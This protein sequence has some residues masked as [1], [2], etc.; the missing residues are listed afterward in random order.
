VLWSPTKDNGDKERVRDASDIVRIV[1][2]SVALRPKG[3]EYSGLCPF[4]DDHRP[5]MNVIPSKQIFHCFVCGASGDVFTFVQKFH[6]MD[7][8]EALEYLAERAGIALT[9]FRAAEGGS[10]TPVGPNRRSLLE[11]NSE[12]CRF[13]RG[14]LAHAEHGKPGREV[15]ERRRISPEMVE[16][17]QIGLAPDRW[18]GLLLWARQRKL[19]E[20]SLLAAG[21]A[22]RRESGDGA[23]D[24]LRHRLIFPIHN[25]AGQVIAFGGRK[26]RDEDEP[27]YLNS[28]E[29]PLFN[30]S[31]TL[32]ALHLATS[33][34]QAERTAIICEGYTDVIA[35]HQ[36]GFTNAVATLGTALTR[37]HA[38]ELRL[39]CDKVVLLFD[40]D[41][42][43][44]RAAD[45]AVPI[46]FAEQIDVAIAT[47]AAHT[48][49]KDP[50]E[51]LKR[52]GGPDVFRNALASAQD[53]IEYRLAR[54]RARLAGAGLSALEKGIVQE[55]SDF[56]AM[57]LATAAPQR[58]ELIER[59]LAEIS[60]LRESTIRAITPV[61][62]SAPARIEPA[63][64]NS[65]DAPDHSAEL[66]RLNTGMLT[67]SEHLLGC[68]LCDG[69]LW[70]TLPEHDR[71]LVAPEAYSSPLVARVATL[72][73]SLG[74][75]EQ[76]P[77]LSTLLQATEDSFIQSAAVCLMSRIAAETDRDDARLAQ[78]W[79]ACLGRAR[80]D[81]AHIKLASSTDDASDPAAKLAQ[82]REIKLN[83]GADRRVMPRPRG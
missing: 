55:I 8:R 24:A 43:G 18:D 38:R 30:K 28:P 52:E 60:G 53:L 51:L 4:H 75:D 1:G 33:K 42:A 65:D 10:A 62:R 54:V 7:F 16:T 45:R 73:K 82:L 36:A 9:P 71:D 49:A 66:A 35:C 63:L 48:D 59:R 26:I 81:R 68:I 27:K 64:P 40:G 80:N 23:Y 19:D 58:R 22:K 41:D 78:H 32:Y 70:G 17:F 3:R 6:K 12:A 56:A 77:A 14:M 72:V 67:A 2:E 83:S 61:G 57:G 46:F 13:F 37:E 69:A 47:L 76:S 79:Q 31:A 34:I 25:K 29:T 21:L 11:V 74:T 39:R 5:S 15:M 50:D 44:Q 20:A